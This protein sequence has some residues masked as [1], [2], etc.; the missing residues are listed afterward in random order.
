MLA[1]IEAATQSVAL[2]SYIF[3]D[4][5][6]AG[7]RFVDALVGAHHRGL[8][9]CVLVD[10]IGSGYFRSSV[11]HRLHAAGVPVGRFMHSTLPW[12][13]PFLNLRSHKKI[14]VLD[15]RIAFT[16][17][18]NISRANVIEL[19]PPAP[20][21]DLHFRVVGPVVAQ[22]MEDFG[23]DW[24]FV[25]DEELDGERWYPDLSPAGDAVSRVI[26]SGPD[27][28]VEKILQ[29]LLCAVASARHSIRVM[30]PYFLPDEALVTALSMAA[31]RGVDVDIVIPE[32]SDHRLID[33]AVKAHVGPALAAGVRIWRNPPPFEHSKLLI[34]DGHWALIG[35][36]NWDMR[37]LRLNFELNVEIYREEIATMLE[38]EVLKRR[39]KPITAETIAARRFPVR[40]RDAATRLLLPYL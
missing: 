32:I 26:T 8:A 37:S 17:G 27:E 13:M 20:V 14:L 24:N 22:L 40:L 11:F 7:A 38:A 33:W 16:G 35:S 18:M 10:G 34:V 2:S 6:G 9:V 4:E 23:R 21:R 28:D 36:A 19:N 39:H 3:F 15:G 30:T 12:R 1:A 5:P 31:V 29:L 25:T